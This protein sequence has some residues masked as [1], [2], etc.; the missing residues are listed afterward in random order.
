MTVQGVKA[1]LQVLDDVEELARA[2]PPID[3][4]GSR[5][6]NPAFRTFYD[7]LTEVRVH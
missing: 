7:K 3:N 4:K 6:G 5:F 1:V 2:T